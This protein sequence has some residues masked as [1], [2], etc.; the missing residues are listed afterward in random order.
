MTHEDQGIVCCAECRKGI[1]RFRGVAAIDV[2]VGHEARRSKAAVLTLAARKHLRVS[3]FSG[4]VALHQAIRLM[5][6]SGESS[7]LSHRRQVMSQDTKTRP[8]KLPEKKIG[9]FASGIGVAIWLDVAHVAQQENR[10]RDDFPVR[11]GSVCCAIFK[12]CGGESS[13]DRP[14]IH[15]SNEVTGAGKQNTFISRIAR[16]PRGHNQ[17]SYQPHDDAG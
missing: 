3:D 15:E 7:V 6:L 17:R 16:I 10:S 2:A 9:P 1:D 8:Q 13:A 12:D 5:S 4:T 14:G 11:S